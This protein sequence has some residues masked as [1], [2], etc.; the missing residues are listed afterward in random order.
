MEL[1][2][3]KTLAD[4]IKRGTIPIEEALPIAK[5]IAAALEEAYEKGIV[6]WDLKPAI[7]AAVLAA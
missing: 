7:W 1:V 3:G 4:R 6:H 2:P 5:Q